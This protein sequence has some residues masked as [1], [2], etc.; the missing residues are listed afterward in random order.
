MWGTPPRRS[1]KPPPSFVCRAL[2]KSTTVHF[3]AWHT[4]IYCACWAAFIQLHLILSAN[5]PLGQKGVRWRVSRSASIL[6]AL[7]HP[8]EIEAKTLEKRTGLT[9]NNYMRPFWLK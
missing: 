6:F 5:S 4:A 8:A 9:C 1:E 3:A 7:K 2:Q